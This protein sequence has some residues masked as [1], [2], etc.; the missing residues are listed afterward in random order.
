MYADQVSPHVPEKLASKYILDPYNVY[1]RCK[2]YLRKTTTFLGLHM[3]K[4]KKCDTTRP[5]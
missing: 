4:K 5:L 2:S 3:G 1:R